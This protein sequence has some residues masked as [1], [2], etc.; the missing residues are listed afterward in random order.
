MVRKLHENNN[1]QG[2]TLRNRDEIVDEL[3]EMLVQFA[4]DCNKYN[5]DV[6]LYVDENGYGSLDTFVNVGGNSW[7]DDDHYTIYTDRQHNESKYDSYDIPELA[8]AVGLSEEELIRQTAMA[9]DI[10]EEDVEWADVVEYIDDNDSLRARFA[11]SFEK[12]VRELIERESY[13]D[14]DE[15]IL[16]WE[17]A[18]S[19]YPYDAA[20]EFGSDFDSAMF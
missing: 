11:K 6:Y 12:L 1:F 3:A 16:G 4:I 2:R 18:E 10:D 19:D 15:I 5:T 13:E 9:L 14:A 7:L 8:E 20:A 17:Y